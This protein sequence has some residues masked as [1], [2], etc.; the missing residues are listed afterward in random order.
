MD[1]LFAALWFFLP[2]GVAN[3]APVFAAKIPGL[4]GWNTPLDFGRKY[5]G[6]RIFGAHKTWRGLLAGI[7]L[8]TAT[9][10]L[11][12]YYFAHNTSV[13]DLS[14]LAYDQPKVWLL[15]PLFGAGALLADAAESFLK[16]QVGVSPG[17]SWFPFDQTDYILGGCL[18]ALP[19]ISLSASQFMWVLISWF[20]AHL[21]GSYTAYLLRLK[22]NPI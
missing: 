7:V 10:A 13:A 21:A 6:Q 15:G 4:S 22:D 12:K 8:A 18:F 3:A 14:W 19:I 20:G 5:K 9:I 16:R 2:A 11:Q 17:D 1:S